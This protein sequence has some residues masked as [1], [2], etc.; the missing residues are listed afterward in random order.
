MAIPELAIDTASIV[1]KGSFRPSVVSPKELVTQGLIATSQ[2]SDAAQKFSTDDISILET[3]RIRFLANRETIQ[4]T[5]QQA[6]EFEVLRDLAVGV[7]RLFASES[8]SVMG[9]NRDAH[10]V[11][12]DVNAWHAVGDALVPKEI[13]S[14]TLELAGMASLT[15]QAARS[16]QYQGYRQIT[17]QPSGLVPQGVYVAHNDHY[18]LGITD[19]APSTR[20]QFSA[21]IRRAV[22]QDQENVS[23]AIAVL[24][25]EWQ[26][27]MQRGSAVI[28]RVAREAKS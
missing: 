7:L 15:I 4:I 21:L 6:D 12:G 18:M 20:E 5:A 3:Q 19:K 17:V 14:D 9:I 22:P 23:I 11:A 10:F 16:G 25:S 28:E 26:Q 2:V 24:N 27:S 13:W 8:I 1:I